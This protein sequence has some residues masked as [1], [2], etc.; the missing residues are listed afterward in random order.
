METGRDVARIR[1][2]PRR[3]HY[4]P[5]LEGDWCPRV[6]E[7]LSERQGSGPKNYF[8]QFTSSVGICFFAG[9]GR[10]EGGTVIGAKFLDN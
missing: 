3:G 8:R 2:R 4:V 7:K 6:A 9:G 5:S 10:A 1:W